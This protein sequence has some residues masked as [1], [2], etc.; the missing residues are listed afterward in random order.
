MLR[1][2]PVESPIAPP[3]ALVL[4]GKVALLVAKALSLLNGDASLSK[5]VSMEVENIITLSD[6]AFMVKTIILAER[7]LVEAIKATNP[8]KGMISV[9]SLLATSPSV[10]MIGTTSLLAIGPLAGMIGTISSLEEIRVKEVNSRAPEESSME[11]ILDSSAAHSN[12]LPQ[13]LI[14]TMPKNSSIDM[15][16]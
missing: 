9:T 11:A 3:L 6:E 1:P 14:G 4:I 15:V 16:A 2:T 12:D 8:S 5:K 13:A 10:G 7:I